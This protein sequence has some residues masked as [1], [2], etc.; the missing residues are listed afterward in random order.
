MKV[1]LKS[2]KALQY[3]YTFLIQHKLNLNQHGEYLE[4]NPF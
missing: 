2:K 4:I 1:R 3:I